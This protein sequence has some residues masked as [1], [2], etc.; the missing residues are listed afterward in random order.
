MSDNIFV[1]GANYCFNIVQCGPN[2]HLRRLKMAQKS[3]YKHTFNYLWVVTLVS[4]ANY[5]IY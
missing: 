3:K 1:G 5:I 4:S 2:Y